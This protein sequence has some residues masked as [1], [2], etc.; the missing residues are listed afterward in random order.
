MKVIPESK[1]IS[2]L[3]QAIIDVA[4][5][6]AID[7]VYCKECKYFGRNLENDTY[8]YCGSGLDDPKE[9]DFCS[10]GERKEKR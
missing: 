3:L 9:D 5:V 4:K 6:D 8:C 7:L 1:T 10:Y 2:K